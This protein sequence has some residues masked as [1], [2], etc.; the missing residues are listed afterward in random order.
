MKL[1][2]L[3][4]T[5]T[6]LED[7]I[8]K[9]GNTYLKSKGYNAYKQGGNNAYNFFS[10]IKLYPVN[11]GQLEEVKNRLFSQ[12]EDKPKL[13]IIA[14]QSELS[15]PLVNGKIMPSLTVYRFDFVKNKMFRKKTL[16]NYGKENKNG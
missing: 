13:P 3:K 16:L 10:N 8:D 5:I 15:T 6:R 1:E 7:G 11:I 4:I 14:Y 9:D 12:T 2:E